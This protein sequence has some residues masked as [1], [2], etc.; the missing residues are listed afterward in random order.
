[1]SH[2]LF[3][4]VQQSSSTE[5]GTPSLGLFPLSFFP[6]AAGELHFVDVEQV[7]S[8]SVSLITNL[9]VVP[10]PPRSPQ[11]GE[12]SVFVFVVKDDFQRP[13]ELH[14]KTIWHSL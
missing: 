1:M 12:L 14:T 2:Y 10:S 8:L 3:F 6:F 4:R 7:F 13:I 11:C 9:V 5:G